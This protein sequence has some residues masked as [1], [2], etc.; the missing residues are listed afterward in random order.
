MAPNLTPCCGKDRRHR[1]QILQ[2]TIRLCTAYRP[3]HDLTDPR[4]RKL[5]AALGNV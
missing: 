1:R 4:L 2:V 3:P 5:A